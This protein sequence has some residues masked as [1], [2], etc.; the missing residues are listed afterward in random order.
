MYKHLVP[1][2]SSLAF[3]LLH[4]GLLTERTPL[5][6]QL[7]RAPK[8]LAS[9]AEKVVPPPQWLHQWTRNVQIRSRGWMKRKGFRLTILISPCLKL[10][11]LRMMPNHV[12]RICL[13]RLRP[14]PRTHRPTEPRLSVV[15][16]V[17]RLPVPARPGSI[18]KMT[19]TKQPS[20]VS[21]H[22]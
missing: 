10:P 1:P 16:T 8:G 18:R 12:A 3:V 19:T 21:Q 6:Q 14:R 2:C 7:L 9:S 22:L 4:S 11:V 20:V 15:K 5:L 13:A 17:F